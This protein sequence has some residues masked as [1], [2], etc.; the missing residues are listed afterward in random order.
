MNY[1]IIKDMEKL[2]EFVEW[3]PDLMENEKYYLA[4]FFRKKYF[5]IIRGDKCQL[6]RVTSTKELIIS[7]IKQM[8]CALGS[9]KMDD[10]T[11]PNEGL[12]LYITPNPRDLELA[13]KRTLIEF[14]NLITKP[15]SNYNPQ[16][17]AMNEIQKACSRKIFIDFDFDGI[18][19]F[20]KRDIINECLNEEAYEVVK[21]RGG[22]HLLVKTESIHPDYKK[23]FYPK[24]T[25]IEGCD[26]RGDG[27][28]PVVGCRQGD[29]IPHFIK[30]IKN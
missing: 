1:D 10:I 13:T 5:P 15:Y 29:F 14:V 24:L 30:K 12:A 27:L 26:V 21:T 6:K 18:D 19:F 22:F 3:L 9:Y 2:Q 4:L 25:K 17:K 7:K 16:S 28:L 11:L 8:E 20:E 23:H